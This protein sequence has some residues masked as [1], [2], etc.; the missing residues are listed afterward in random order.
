MGQDASRL[1]TLSLEPLEASVSTDIIDTARPT[2]GSR[3]ARRH[4][5]RSAEISALQE[6]CASS[7]SRNEDGR[8]ARRELPRSK[9]DEGGPRASGS[10]S[11]RGEEEET[12]GRLDT[13][14][15]ARA[16]LWKRRAECFGRSRVCFTGSRGDE[17]SPATPLDHGEASALPRGRAESPT[18]L[19]DEQSSPSAPRRAAREEENLAY[20]LPSQ[21]EA[22]SVRMK[23]LRQTPLNLNSASRRSRRGPRRSRRRASASESDRK[24]AADSHTFLKN[25]SRV[26]VGTS[27]IARR[28]SPEHDG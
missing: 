10:A 1:H 18:L 4:L 7:K 28:V 9:E 11:R 5:R 25:C 16:S 6:R 22:E 27:D 21:E 2:R 15:R 17:Q 20:R 19:G 3:A 26:T 12:P 24:P 8:L 14:R 13:P 23:R